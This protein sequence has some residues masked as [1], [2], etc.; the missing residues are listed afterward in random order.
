M[1]DELKKRLYKPEEDFKERKRKDPHIQSG[2]PNISHEWNS[3]DFQSSEEIIG[4]S[5]EILK[6]MKRKKRIRNFIIFAVS[7]VVVLTAAFF[8]AYKYYIKGGGLGFLSMENIEI[9]IDSPENANAGE[10][11]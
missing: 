8:L 11:F 4:K 10:R 1:L 2:E 3:H 7:F 5:K 6:E 9:K